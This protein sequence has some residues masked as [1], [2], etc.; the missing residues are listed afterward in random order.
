[1]RRAL[2]G[3]LALT[4]LLLPVAGSAQSP[5]TRFQPMQLAATA[6]GNGNVLQT[7]DLAVVVLQTSGTFTATVTYEATADG[8][9]FATLTCYTISGSSGVTTAAAAAV[10]RCNVAGWQGIRAR[11]S[12]Y[13]SGSVTVY[14]SGTSIPMP[15]AA[16]TN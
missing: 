13:T 10:V 2:S 12:A 9:N 16:T 5:V 11:V 8:T 6:T 1:M 3:L 14:G 7:S 4:L 15:F